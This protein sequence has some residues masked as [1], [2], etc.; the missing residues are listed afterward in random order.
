MEVALRLAPPSLIA[1]PHRNKSSLLQTKS[2][3]Y[4][5]HYHTNSAQV[6]S[7]WGDSSVNRIPIRHAE[8][9]AAKEALYAAV[10]A[11]TD[12]VAVCYI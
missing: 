2:P 10:I 12:Q 5:N 11:W 4:V 7:L 6:G 1:Q 9:D 8:V 3:E